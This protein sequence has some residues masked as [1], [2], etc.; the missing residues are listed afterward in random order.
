[1]QIAVVFFTVIVALVKLPS[2]PPQI[3]LFYSLS[4]GQS[5]V[6]DSYMM[7]VLPIIAILFL[8][9]NKFVLAKLAEDNDLTK[10]ILRF[11]NIGIVILLSLICVKILLLVT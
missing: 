8:L 7:L 9:F 4:S 10:S 3:P 11:T 5:R 2:L 6:V 1:M